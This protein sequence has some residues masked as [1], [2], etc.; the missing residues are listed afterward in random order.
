MQGRKTERKNETGRPG[1]CGALSDANDECNTLS[2]MQM[3]HYFTGCVYTAVV[4]LGQNDQQREG[5]TVAKVLTLGAI[6]NPNWVNRVPFIK[7]LV[8]QGTQK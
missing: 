1:E 2:I 7:Y 4:V 8:P 5:V 3:S 6:D